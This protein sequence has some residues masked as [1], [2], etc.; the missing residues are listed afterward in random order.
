[1]TRDLLEEIYLG[2]SSNKIRSG[3]TMLGIVIG[4]GSVIAM[5]SVGQ[6]AKAQIEANIQSIGSNLLLVMPGAQ[7]GVGTAVNTG[8][9][10]SQ[11]L[12]SEDAE[13]VKTL[14][15]VAA[16]APELSRRYQ[17]T[18]RG[19]NTNTQIVG[20]GPGY[21][22]VRNVAM[23]LGSFFSESQVTSR[24]KVAVLGPTTRDD[25][26]GIDS[27]PIGQSIRV[28]GVDFTVIGI[29]K[30]KG[31]SGFANQDDTIFVPLSSMQVFLSGGKMVSTISIQAQDQ[32]S[33]TSIQEAV[34]SLLLD[35]HNIS[36]PL[37]ADFSVLNQ[38]DLV[39]AAS[40]ITDT[41]TTLLAS[42][43]GISLLV[44]GIGIMNMMLTTVTERTREIGLRQAIGAEKQAIVGQFLG[45]AVLLTVLG[46][47][48][49]VILGY[50]ASQLISR[51]AQTPTTVSSSSVALAFGVSALIGLVFG[52][53][54]AQRAA[55]LN[56]IEA[57]RFE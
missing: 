50:G 48:I 20:T 56:P 19:K 29:T 35:R 25:L 8:R 39:S 1:M 21:L 12:T 6:G 4:I 52:F 36:N 3:L 45:E 22:Q 38:S 11:T 32:G 31:G 41:F 23:D 17:V 28:N 43:A 13:A 26:F 53:Y 37:Q 7:R 54:P 2:V 34:T 51:L 5:L 42:I 46:G 24:A 15:N 33:M 47:L 30:A 27:V 14:P 9:G 44:G 40:S 55:K 10:S 18:A 16:V 57:L 49:G